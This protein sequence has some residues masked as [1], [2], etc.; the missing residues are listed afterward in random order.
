MSDFEIGYGKPPKKSQ[1]KSGVSG[2]PKGRPQRKQTDLAGAIAGVLQTPIEHQEGGQKGAASGWE[3]HLRMLVQRAVRGD[4]EAAMT[5][6]SFRLQAERRKG[7]IQRIEIQDWL[8]DYP[9]QTAEE[10]TRA[11]VQRKSS[12]AAEWWSQLPAGQTKSD[13]R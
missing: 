7:G 13:Q 2:N 3:L 12:A 10:K 6:L 8:P 4:V 9:G 1:F 5:V 11:F